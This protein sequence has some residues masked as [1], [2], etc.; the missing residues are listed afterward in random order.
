MVNNENLDI[1][2]PIDLKSAEE[3][4]SAIIEQNKKYGFTSFALTALSKGWRA[5]GYPPKEHYIEVAKQFKYVKGKLCN[6]NFEIGWYMELSV[7]S[8]FSEG[9][10]PIVK[11]N[12][13]THPFASCPLDSVFKKRLT[14]DIALF[15]QIA[16]PAFIFVEDDFSISSANGCFCKEHLNEFAKRTGRYY[17]REELLDIFSKDTEESLY[18]LK[19]WNEL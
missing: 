6:Y 3:T 4:V 2:I 1:I 5:T 16:K 14:E 11:Q 18:L 9:F 8:G 15:A 17:S 12:G 13:D 10:Q 19:K 7:K